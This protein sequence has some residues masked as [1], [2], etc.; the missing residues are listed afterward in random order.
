MRSHIITSGLAIALAFSGVIAP[1]VGQPIDWTIAQVD[2]TSELDR[3]IAEVTRLFKEGSA[4]S[5]RKEIGQFE[6]ALEL[7]RST[8]AKDKQ[9]LS[10]LFLGRIYDDLGEKQKALDYFNQALPLYRAVGDRGGEVT[11]L[12]NIGGVYSALGEKQKALDYFNQALP[13]YRAVG[14]RSGEAT[15]LN[16]IGGVYSALGEK[17]KALEYYNQALPLGRAANRLIHKFVSQAVQRFQR[18]SLRLFQSERIFLERRNQALSI[19]P[20]SNCL[21][22]VETG[23]KII[24]LF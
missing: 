6:K 16:N 18:I 20:I 3:A 5:L 8:Q 14:D 2:K 13:L 9:A 23:F 7:A 17:Q 1:V 4:E 15:T 10:L 19:V 12:N 11:T 22:L 21:K 24:S